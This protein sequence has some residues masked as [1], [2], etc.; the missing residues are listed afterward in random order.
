[1][2]PYVVDILLYNFD[3]HLQKPKLTIDNYEVDLLVQH[4][5]PVPYSTVVLPCVGAFQ[6]LYGHVEVPTLSVDLHAVSSLLCNSLHLPLSLNESVF[7][8][9]VSFAEVHVVVLRGAA[10]GAPATR[11]VD[12]DVPTNVAVHLQHRCGLLPY[13]CNIKKFKS[14]SFLTMS[15]SVYSRA[16]CF[17]SQSGLLG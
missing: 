14:G 1:M 11:A 2:N 16:L 8:V 17:L 15:V 9:T 7:F 13:Y 10:V 12:R 5:K 6:L 3:K 4:S